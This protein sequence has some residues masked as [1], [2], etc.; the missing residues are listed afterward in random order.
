M[1][2]S[3]AHAKAVEPGPRTTRPA[4]HA[5]SVPGR[6]PLALQDAVGNRALDALLQARRLQ[7]K[8]QIS[9]PGDPWELEADRVAATVVVSGSP[10]AIQ[11]ECA[12]GGKTP[13]E[14]EGKE[15][16]VRRKADNGGSSS[17]DAPA[18]LLP[19]PGRPL[20]CATRDFFE[21]RFG[22]DFGD[23][24]IH[25]GA[26]AA[27]S[28]REL[29]AEAFTFGSQIAFAPGRYAPETESGKRL[30]AHELT[31][32][33]QQGGKGDAIV[34]RQERT[35]GA[36]EAEDV[37]LPEGPIIF[38]EFGPPDDTFW[39]PMAAGTVVRERELTITQYS[40]E[41]VTI[42]YGPSSLDIRSPSDGKYSFIV[43][44]ERRA[45]ENQ[46][47]GFPLVNLEKPEPPR[48]RV[49][50]VTATSNVRIDP[51][52]VEPS[53]DPDQPPF[54]QLVVRQRYAAVADI[55]TGP[56]SP[57]SFLPELR[58]VPLGNG[59]T[60]LELDNSAVRIIPPG[61]NP[62]LRAEDYPNARY[63][64]WIDPLWSG[65]DMRERVVTIV[66]SP[67]VSM[68]TGTLP[69]VPEERGFGRSLVPDLIRVPHPSLV[70]EQG[71]PI[72]P[73]Q[74]LGSQ[75]IVPGDAEFR[76][77]FGVGVPERPSE[78][79]HV[80]T[81]HTGVSIAHPY[82]GTV[83]TLR[84][85]EPSIGGAYAWQVL[86]AEGGN[87]AEFRIVV[88]PRVRVAMDEPLPQRLRV[89]GGAPTPRKGKAEIGQGLADER[90]NLFIVEV[91]LNEMVP[92][93]GTPINVNHYL[94]I[95][96]WLRHPDEHRWLG[97]N[98]L[99]YDIA[100]TAVDVGIGMIPVIGDLIDIGEFV[101]ALFTD[102]DRW[103]R[104]V[105]T[106][107]KVLMGVG[108]VI[109]L[110]PLLGGIGSLL[111]GGTRATVK[112]AEAARMLRKTPEQLETI[113]LRVRRSV[114]GKDAQVLDRAI[115]AIANGEE[116][117]VKD[118]EHLQRV[119]ARMGPA[120]LARARR[121]ATIAGELVE[122]G[123]EAARPALVLGT[124]GALWRRTLNAETLRYLRENPSLARVYEE[125][126]AEVRSVLTRCGSLCMLPGRPTPQQIKR[127]E[128]IEHL[129][130]PD[131]QELELLRTHFR[132]HPG[133]L[134]GGI[135]AL[136][137]YVTKGS[138]RRALRRQVNVVDAVLLPKR[139]WRESS[140][141]RATVQ[142]LLDRGMPA[143]QLAAI[144]RSAERAGEGG[145][146]VLH[147][148]DQLHILQQRGIR[149]ADDALSQL[150]LGR[151]F[152]TGE[153]WVLR[154]ID[155]RNLWKKVEQFEQWAEVTGSRRWD[156]RIAGVRYQFKSWNQFYD[157]TFVKQIIE[158]YK[159]TDGLRKPLRW[160]FDPHTAIGSTDEVLA[161]A[162]QA[163]E[164]AL[165]KG[166]K[167]LTR[168]MVN[169]I[170]DRLPR[171]IVVPSKAE[172]ARAARLVP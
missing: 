79:V 66:A 151:G 86:P 62:W 27:A 7:A 130:K 37:D 105:S 73:G 44:A 22:H 72:D 51:H 133:G 92:P 82:S 160:V 98:D 162:T 143:D 107:D 69:N 91:P 9:E 135:E 48:Q 156:A 11:R 122:A 36:K 41:Q 170:I 61:A 163:L 43:E 129:L 52:L 18:E 24:R 87:P 172:V 147:Y 12:C 101:G 32:V 30:L 125:M 102:R 80:A 139:G 81:A 33:V 118:L 121:G 100:T 150:A 96:G 2:S 77:Q 78:I 26:D 46:E 120:D 13:C 47:S 131:A 169:D 28:A 56:P 137:K 97:V 148:V 171:I 159:N 63:A 153:E 127:V 104:E 103:G 4:T 59:T 35:A 54:P 38:Q 165:R 124:E 75:A 57:F 168:A 53:T 95:G 111:R 94:S 154:Y 40:P 106:F 108:A 25:T 110:I 119:V 64:Y 85:A 142:R 123:E 84:P 145:R 42:Q 99:P 161:A 14:C 55:D 155:R 76:L 17:A 3:R 70:P 158:D 157:P 49:V 136:E 138:L 140:E 152:F 141:L 10:P 29:A 112:F 146:R 1:E 50:R 167:E 67:G 58:E 113:V 90:I 20:D 21:P 39:G 115:H 128:A 164:D 15:A 83:V 126:P 71:E 5:R 166:G 132:L 34:H 23:V 109:G 117:A 88:G 93:L 134:Q 60:Q 144:M 65:P 6:S 16:L 19:S 116:I 149:G 74:F 31:H 89:E 8:R 114:Y 45:I 68:T